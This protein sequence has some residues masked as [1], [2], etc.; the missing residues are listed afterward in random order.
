MKKLSI[1]VFLLLIAGVF[2]YP[3]QVASLDAAIDQAADRIERIIGANRKIAVLNFTSSSK[4]LS[5]YVIDELMDIFINNRVL[6]VIERSRIDAVL[7]ERN[8][9]TSG[10]ANDEE[11]RSIGSQLGA[12]FV[13]LGQLDYSGIA[14]RF[15]LYAVDI[16]KG[17]RVASTSADIRSNSRQLDYFLGGGQGAAD[18]R[19]QAAGS[20][21][22]PAASG[23]EETRRS[24]AGGR[25]EK[26]TAGDM[27]DNMFKLSAGGG[28]LGNY[29]FEKFSWVEVDG[30]KRYEETLEATYYELGAYAGLSAE[31]FS[32]VLL[33]ASGYFK[34]LNIELTDDYISYILKENKNESKY[35][36]TS[37]NIFG[38]DLALYV[39]YPF[40]MNSK[41]ALFPLAGVGYEM[42]FY[43][44]GYNTSAY[45][46]EVN[47]YI[48][49]YLKE[50]GY[51]K[52]L[53]TLYLRAGG[54][55]YYDFTPR[56]RLNAKLLY[57][58]FLYNG[59]IS[60]NVKSGAFESVDFSLHG[61][62]LSL[63]ISYLF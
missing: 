20:S 57:N 23:R 8:F 41:L 51:L 37:T 17:T 26:R 42:M 7:R 5:S 25:E 55:F 38:L 44:T 3:Q 60:N 61:P 10:E 40:Q 48:N 21:R 46:G 30:S 13:I 33:D 32:Y 34:Q 27:P 52:L 49:K 35:I 63:G 19:Q 53:D 56:L 16:E 24:A 54:G 4:E 15:R 62:G 18:S 14:Y 59:F 12:A 1:G 50:Q 36:S 45:S 39:K 47:D 31:F 29:R 22:Q 6:E 58:I 28:L 9:Q 11:I 43:S 2:A